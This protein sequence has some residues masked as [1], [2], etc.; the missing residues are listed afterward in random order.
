[1]VD[2][3]E[4]SKPIWKS[5]TFWLAILQIAVGIS[6]AFQQQLLTGASISILGVIFI[7]L[8]VVSK[9]PIVSVV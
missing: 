3:P 7:I 8:R 9:S 5:R 2:N 6:D 4:D 1:M